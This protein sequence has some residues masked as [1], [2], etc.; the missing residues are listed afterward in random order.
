M[1]KLPQSELIRF[2]RERP[3]VSVGKMA[4][5][6]GFNNFS[7]YGLVNDKCKYTDAQAEKLAIKVVPVMRKYGFDPSLI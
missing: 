3:S 5:E 7:L 1:Q 4:K 6:S 2:F